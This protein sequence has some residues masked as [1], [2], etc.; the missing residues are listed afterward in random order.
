MSEKKDHIA[1]TADH[2]KA[3]SRPS[4]RSFLKKTWGILGIIA[5]MEMAVITWS[6]L[7][8]GRKRKS[9]YNSSALK[10]VGKVSDFGLNSVFPFRDG[11]F[12]LVRLSD[13]GF[14]ALSLKCSHLGCSVIW[15]Q[16]KEQ[17]VC[18]CHSSSFDLHGDVINPPAPRALDILPVLIEEGMVKVDT[19]K[20]LKR[21]KFEKSDLVYT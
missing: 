4:R 16:E 19:G 11:R 6:F 9:S 3:V 20:P 8:P 14:L 10:T 5:G 21:K 13:G 7:T 2:E 1:I 17:F 15:D 12:Y 18:P